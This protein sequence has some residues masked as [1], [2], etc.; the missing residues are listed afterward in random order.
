[1]KPQTEWKRHIKYLHMRARERVS[2]VSMNSP[3]FGLKNDSGNTSSSTDD[4]GDP[5]GAV[6]TGEPTALLPP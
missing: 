6:V 1:M 2:G 3:V 5:S 4:T